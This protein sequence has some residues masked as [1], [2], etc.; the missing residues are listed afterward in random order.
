MRNMM[1]LSLGCFVAVLMTAG[2]ALGNGG[3]W[4]ALCVFLVVRGL[5]LGLLYPRRLAQTFAGT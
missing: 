2:P 4:L 5:S 1:L 3:L